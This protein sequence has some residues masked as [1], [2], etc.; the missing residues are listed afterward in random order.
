MTLQD[1]LD[2]PSGARP[3]TAG[4]AA[5]QPACRPRCTWPASLLRYRR[6]RPADR[7]RAVRGRAR[8]AAARPADPASTT[9]TFGDWLPAHGQDPQTVAA[10]WDLV[11]V[12]TL[13]AARRRRVAGAGRH[14]LPDRAAHRRRG[15]ATSAGRW[16][17]C[18]G[19][20]ATPPT[21]ALAAAGGEVRTS[22]EGR[23][24]L[25]ARR[26][27][28][29][30]RE[31]GGESHRG[32]RG[33]A[34]RAAAGR[35]R[36]CCPA[37][38]LDLEPG[39]SARLGSV[40]DRQRARRLRPPGLDDPFVAGVGTPAQWVFDRTVAVGPDRTGQYLAVSLSAADDFDRRRRPRRSGDRLLPA[41]PRCSRPRG[42]ARSSTS[43]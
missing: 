18:S 41:W 27:R 26:G 33:R 34:G 9:Q 29:D 38:A 11:G 43:S 6:C 15:A 42:D 28:L 12:A 22:G 19:C 2:I 25:D 16:C 23:A 5:A 21:P 30:R 3:A 24:A 36:R 37:G 1:R 35:P 20:T 40:A 8:A 17:R 10:L 14:G 32:R 31:R 39:W 13:N 7:L 4:P